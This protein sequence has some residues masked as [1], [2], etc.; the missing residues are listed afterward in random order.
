MITPSMMIAI[1]TK[2]EDMA[3][4]IRFVFVVGRVSSNAYIM[5]TVQWILLLNKFYLSKASFFFHLRRKRQ[6]KKA[7]RARLTSTLGRYMDLLSK[8]KLLKKSHKH[9]PITLTCM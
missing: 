8:T 2:S 7:S 3:I 6:G 5:V 1:A 4:I 9:F